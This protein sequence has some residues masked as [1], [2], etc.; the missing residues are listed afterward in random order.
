[1]ASDK[2]LFRQRFLAGRQTLEQDRR[3]ETDEITF[4]E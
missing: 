3:L 4:K 2:Q 1:M